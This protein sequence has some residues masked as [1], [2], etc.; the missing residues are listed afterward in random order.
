MLKTSLLFGKRIFFNPTLDYGIKN[1]R[2]QYGLLN[3]ENF[4][5]KL[6]YQDKLITMSFLQETIYELKYIVR[7]KKLVS[8]IYASSLDYKKESVIQSYNNTINLFE[9]ILGK[10][11]KEVYF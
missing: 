9:N 8:H 5:K 10:L 4:L 11:K 2:H 7:L 6:N 1:S 3:V